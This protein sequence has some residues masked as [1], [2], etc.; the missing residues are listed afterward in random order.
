MT[1]TDF[2]KKQLAAIL[3]ARRRRAA[4]PAPNKGEALR[5]SAAAPSGSAC[6][7]TMCSPPRPACSTAA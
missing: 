5:A 3:S 1:N 2:S 4:Q 6:P 7:P